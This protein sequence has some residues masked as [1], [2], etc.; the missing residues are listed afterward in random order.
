MGK[1]CA[2][3]VAITTSVCFPIAAL[4][5]AAVVLYCCCCCFYLLLFL[6]VLL[7]QCLCVAALLAAVVVAFAVVIVEL[8]WLQWLRCCSQ[9][10]DCLNPSFDCGFAD[11]I[12]VAVVVSVV[13]LALLV[14]CRYC[15]WRW[16]SCCWCCWCG[17]AQVKVV[18]VVEANQYV[19]RVQQQQQ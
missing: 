15:W 10:A 1:Y 13:S 6:L 12:V 18:L 3:P 2:A 7:L 5:V 11:V 17:E 19:S 9:V 14:L 4:D 16:S 8:L